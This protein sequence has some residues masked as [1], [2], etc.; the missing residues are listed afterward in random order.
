MEVMAQGHLPAPTRVTL[1]QAD[2]ARGLA[3]F[4][5]A[6]AGDTEVHIQAG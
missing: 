5:R 3:P 6:H 2:R 1:A 4:T